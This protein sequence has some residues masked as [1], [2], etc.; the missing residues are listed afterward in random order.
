MKN[1]HSHILLRKISSA[2][3][4]GT[5]VHLENLLLHIKFYSQEILIPES[6]FYQNQPKKEGAEKKKNE[7]SPHPHTAPWVTKRTCSWRHKEK[8]K[9]TAKQDLKVADN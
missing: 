3:E 6:Q 5:H 2:P 1:K 8:E 7:D 4:T 9:D